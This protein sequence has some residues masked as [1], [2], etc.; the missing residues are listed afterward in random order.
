MGR[1]VSTYISGEAPLSAKVPRA[2]V[3][4]TLEFV[5]VSWASPF[6]VIFNRREMALPRYSWVG[7]S[8]SSLYWMH[9]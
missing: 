5:P 1:A 2:P 8:A 6:G 3:A 4:E 9:G 7:Q